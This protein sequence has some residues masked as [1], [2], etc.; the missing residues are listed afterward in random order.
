M[1]IIGRT[2]G[3]ATGGITGNIEAALGPVHCSGPFGLD[4]SLP[5]LRRGRVIR[6]GV[7]QRRVE[8]RFAFALEFFLSGFE[9][10]NVRGDAV[11]L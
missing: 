7:L 5:N 3:T 2:T 11:S 4:G 9:V 6:P 1:D 10:R 8:V